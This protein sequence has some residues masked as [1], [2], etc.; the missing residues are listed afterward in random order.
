VIHSMTAFGRTRKEADGLT[1]TLEMRTLNGRSLDIVL[2][3]PKNMLEFEDLLR[4]KIAQSLRRGRVE[5]FVQ[6]ECTVIAQKT[7]QISIPLAGHYWEQLQELHRQLPGTDRPTLDHLLR[8]PY[9][10]ETKDESDRQELMKR[11]L[12]EA[13]EEVLQEIVAMR[14]REGEALR[15][16]CLVRLKSLE[17]DL[18]LIDS[19]K[20]LVIEE[21]QSRLT[22]RIQELLGENSFDE[23]RV[24]QEVACLAERSDINEETVRLWSHFRQIRDLLDPSGSGDGRKLDFMAQELH[25]ETNTIGCKTGDIDMIQAVVRMKGEI[26]KL[27][28]QVQNIE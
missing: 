16:D 15:E 3:L 6:V 4:K 20:G 17:D 23:N 9:I 28:E 7:P 14:A 10:F 22:A 12:S 26:A 21:F 8:I 13:I 24:L 5:V 18:T 11:A 2:R 19:R 27:K 25:R 1:V